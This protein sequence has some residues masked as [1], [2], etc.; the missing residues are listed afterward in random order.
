[1]QCQKCGSDN[2]QGRRFCAECG[3]A[4]ATPCAEC[5][6]A[7]EAGEKFCGG[8]GAPLTD[9]TSAADERTSTVETPLATPGELRQVTIMFADLSGFTK[10]SQ[11]LAPEDTHALLNRFFE[12]LDGVV[13]SF[14]GRIDKHMGDSVMAVFGAPVAHS[15]DPERAIR[16]A[17]GIHQAVSG[18]SVD[19]PMRVHIGIAS[20]QVIA[21]GTGSGTHQEYTVT[22]DSVNLAARLQDMAASGE[23]C[24]SDAVHIAVAHLVSAEAMEQVSIRG[25]ER[26]V[27]VWRLLGLEE[28]GAQRPERSF[29]GRQTE[30]RQFTGAV[31]VCAESGRGQS[32]YVR[33][34]AGIGKTRLIEEFRASA[35]GAG[36]ACHT[37]LVLDFG[38]GKGQDA[39][40]SVVRSL[41]DIPA[42][43]GK[44]VRATTAEK[45]VARGLVSEAD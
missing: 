24:I 31:E 27:R 16:S 35:E 37:G 2:R 45:A 9:A 40:R 44:A 4:L 43:S 19:R 6:F 32:I 42:G 41:L 11:E 22:G 3:A 36:F 34:E 15:N 7:N 28:A 39:I 17:L 38:V 12:A 26:P 33:G 1:M 20:G 13:Q 30:L 23:T 21:S 29:V 25:L 14:D 10:L 5:G 18:L 8:C